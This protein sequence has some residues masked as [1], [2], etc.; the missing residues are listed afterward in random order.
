MEDVLRNPEV[1][2]Y[3]RQTLQRETGYLKEMEEFARE[4]HVPIIPPETAALLK[5]FV[6]LRKPLRILEAGTAIGYS[7]AI[8]A[9]A[10]PETGRV[11]TLELDEDRAAQAEENIRRLGLSHKIRVLKGDALEIM[12][13]LQTP[14]DML[15]MDASKGRYPEYLPECIRLTVPGGL[16]LSDNVLYKGLVSQNEPVLHKHRTITTRLKAYLDSLCSDK[17]LETAIVP[18]GDGLA[19]SYR[20]GNES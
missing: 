15:F 7:A 9:M 13:C 20:K 2:L 16:I 4:H 6:S 18:I 11:D 14:Y 10:M 12:Q 1:D 8:M 17:R 3:L 19:V 5:V